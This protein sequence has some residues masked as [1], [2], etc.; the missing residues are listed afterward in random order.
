MLRAFRNAP[1]TK[2]TFISNPSPSPAWLMPPDCWKSRT[3][4]PSKPAFRRARRYSASY[5]PK[6][7]GP[8]EPAVTKTYLSMMSCR[9][10][11]ARLQ[12]LQVFDQVA[13]REVGRVALPVV[14]LFP[15]WNEATS[16]VG[17]TS[18]LCPGRLER[19]LDQPLVLRRQAAEE[20]RDTVALRCRKRAFGGSLEMGARL[21]GR[22][23]LKARA[24]RFDAPLDFQLDCFACAQWNRADRGGRRRI[25]ARAHRTSFDGGS[26]RD[27]P[28]QKGCADVAC[29][30]LALSG[31]F[32][33][34]ELS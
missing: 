27:A 26:G 17:S 3:R 23:R 2:S 30:N 4:K 1:R 9:E 15:S 13:H 16:G 24:F 19:R 25:A 18:T 6:R 32:D 8:Q 33:G 11:P 31:V 34:T 12:M 21:L 14:V 20:D 10:T 22:T 28:R 29:A 7:H 5:M